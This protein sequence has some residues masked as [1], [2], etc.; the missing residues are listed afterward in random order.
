VQLNETKAD[1][2]ALL[3]RLDERVDAA[4]ARG[5]RV[6][7]FRALDETDWR[8]PVMHVAISGLPRAKLRQHLEARYVVGAPVDAGGFPAYELRP[9]APEAYKAP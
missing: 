7:V 6:L 4:F 3:A 9:R 8:G 2:A 1:A 5:G